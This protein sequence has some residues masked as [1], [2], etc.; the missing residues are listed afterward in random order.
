MLEPYKNPCVPS[1]CG[2]NSICQET[3]NIPSCTCMPTYIGSPPNCRP[4]CSITAEC[5]SSEACIQQKCRNPC[6]GS[7]GIN[8]LCTVT[9]HV[10]ICTCPIGYTG[11][12]FSVCAPQLQ[13]TQ[14]DPPD[15]CNP[16][17]CGP[18]AICQD[19]TCT[20]VNEHFGDPYYGC[21]PECVLSSD[22]ARDRACVRNKCVDP[23][24]GTCASNAIC[25]VINHVPMCSCT[26]GMTGNAFY[27]C[28][29]IQVPLVTNPCIPSPCGQN[30]QC[31]EVNGQAVCSCVP[32]YIG[33][34]P[35][36]RPECSIS[37]D[38]PLDKACNNQKCINPC[39]GSCGVGA[40]CEVIKHNP[41]CSCPSMYT[42]DPFI[43]CSPFSK[44]STYT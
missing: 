19:G 44:F 43:R 18:N 35:L 33:S 25:N 16:S 3:G 4:E 8:A 42:G 14:Q 27:D 22:C 36:C 26:Q 31:R 20:C 32:G 9:N 1:P 17:P 5:P 40:K 24:K 15:K 10:P 13:A 39:V 11:D 37:S 30:S 23:C 41:I 7:C 28:Q 6:Q 2:P 34:P 38:C 12:A 21:R 29:P